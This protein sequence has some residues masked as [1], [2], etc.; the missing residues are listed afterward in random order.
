MPI[1]ENVKF[2]ITDRKN[3]W[4]EVVGVKK[5]DVETV[6]I[7]SSIT[8]G[9]KEYKVTSI[10]ES[11]FDGCS[12]LTSITLPNS[13]NSIGREAFWRCKSLTSITLPSSLTSIGVEAFVSC[14]NLAKI[15][16]DSGNPVYDSRDNCNAIIETKSNTLIFG[17]ASTIIP[18]S[19]TS[20][21]EEAFIWCK[22]LTSITIPSSVTSIG[23]GVF[24]CCKN[25][26]SITIPS[27]VTSIGENAFSGCEN[28]TSI[29][30]PA[31]ITNIDELDIP[32]G[33]RIIRENV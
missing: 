4:V 33:T 6:I 31:H 14:D 9:G 21:G 12:S 20:I 5:N 22:S 18:S 16:V 7:P 26:T 17:C 1:V 3:N 27:S 11:A 30:L 13:V 32:K 28:L 29:T 23:D 24:F 2:K 25:L 15:K 10:G 8:T 19:V